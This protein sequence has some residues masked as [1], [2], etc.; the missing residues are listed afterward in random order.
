MKS[1]KKK[2]LG[3]L[4]SGMTTVTLLTSCAASDAYTNEE[5][6]SDYS[7][8]TGLITTKTEMTEEMESEKGFIIYSEAWS[9]EGIEPQMILVDG[10][11]SLD[12]EYTL[13]NDLFIF[14]NDGMIIGYA[15]EGETLKV[16][17]GNEEW[18]R[19]YNTENNDLDEEFFFVKVEGLK[20]ATDSNVVEV[21]KEQAQ[22]TE[23]LASAKTQEVEPV[24]ETFPAIEESE[25]EKP[26]I[27]KPKTE[28]STIASESVV[29]SESSVVEPESV[30]QPESVESTKYTPEEA[31]AVYRSIMEANGIEWDPSIKEFASWG[32]GWIYLDKGQPEWAGN[33]SVEAFKMGGGDATHPW[34]KY[35]LEVTGSDE[36]VVYITGWNCD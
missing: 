12:A 21:R 5:I 14:N 7:S 35:Y 22:E 25:T 9:L 31:I 2:T 29:E 17:D 19:I 6:S 27:E 16:A 4:L 18:F 11:V 32:T 24:Q 30:I 20:S 15:K 1:M 33:S 13:T 28:V 26:K 8:D 34:T 36:N 23:L 10:F 3:L